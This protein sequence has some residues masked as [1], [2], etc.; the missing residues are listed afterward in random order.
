MGE[1]GKKFY[2]N[3]TQELVQ[4]NSGLRQQRNL[5]RILFPK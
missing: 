1:I 5:S 3:A 4:V 2:Q